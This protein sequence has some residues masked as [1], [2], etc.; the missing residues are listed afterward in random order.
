MILGNPCRVCGSCERYPSG[1]CVRCNKARVVQRRAKTPSTAKMGRPSVRELVDAGRAVELYESGTS[2]NTLGRM[3][4]V[5]QNTIKRILAE[6]GVEFR[7]IR[8][9]RPALPRKRAPYH[10]QSSMIHYE[11]HG[12]AEQSDKRE[13]TL[14]VAGLF[15]RPTKAQLMA[16]K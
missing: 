1:N 6:E 2:M 5:S 10:R 13:V 15:W 12:D 4:G 3:F 8:E 16:G 14:P 11:R 7:A 9:R